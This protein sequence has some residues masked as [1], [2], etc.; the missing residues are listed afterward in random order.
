MGKSRNRAQ[1]THLRLSRKKNHI[2]K[3]QH[4]NTISPYFM[5]QNTMSE[6]FCHIKYFSHT[7]ISQKTLFSAAPGRHSH[8]PDHKPVPRPCHKSPY[9]PHPSPQNYDVNVA[10]L[11]PTLAHH[12][13]PPKSPQL[14][15]APYGKTAIYI[16][17]TECQPQIRPKSD[18]HQP[19]STDPI[20]FRS[21]TPTFR[22]HFLDT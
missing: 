13:A 19:Q 8:S 14:R 10:P 9:S 18:P 5:S 21:T 15:P 7:N 1:K 20:C 16:T 12:P 17:T 22:S 6:I 11:I 3:S 2:T 4:K